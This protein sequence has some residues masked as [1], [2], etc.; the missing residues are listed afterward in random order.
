M[1]KSESNPGG[2]TDL[3]RLDQ[4]GGRAIEGFRDLIHR[5]DRCDYF[6][7]R[8]RNR[9]S[10]EEVMSSLSIDED[11]FKERTLDRLQLTLPILKRHLCRLSQTLDPFNSQQTTKLMLRSI[12]QI[13]LELEST[14]EHAQCDVAVLYPEPAFARVR[15]NDQ[16]LKRLKSFR[17]D[18]VGENFKRACW[19]ISGSLKAAI[20]LVEQMVKKDSPE[21]F[22]RQSEEHRGLTAHVEEA[23]LEIDS[24][25]EYIEG[26]DW[27]LALKDLQWDIESTEDALRAT[28]R[29]IKPETDTLAPENTYLSKNFV[30]EPVIQI[31]GLLIPTIKMSRLFLNKLTRRGINTK[32]LPL[33][34]E[35]NSEQIESLTW[36]LC[37][38]SYN[39]DSFVCD[40]HEAD[41]GQGIVP[42]TEFIEYAKEIKFN[43][44]AP[45][46]I[47]LLHLVPAIPD[48]EG[49]PTQ[50]Y[51]KRWFINWNTQRI[52]AI[53][54]FISFAGSL[55]PD[56]L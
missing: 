12:F 35:M 55:G 53:D 54:N 3:L 41:R 5:C 21:E 51:Y 46:L 26:S 45:L 28:A 31:A 47:V 4:P 49:F 1:A 11:I 27:D 17:L 22:R 10:I 25:I 13:Q 2:Q 36:S 56:S 8:P 33:F 20:K 44:E 30:R 14:M 39:L 6:G 7:I 48:T 34:T 37:K 24:T 42:H 40:L 29:K 16:H 32:R 43:F 9:A 38:I 23:A 50:N 18:G 19:A 52:L 15:S